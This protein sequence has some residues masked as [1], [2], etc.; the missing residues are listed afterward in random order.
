MTYPT[1]IDTF[2]PVVASVTLA[3]AEQIN[4][5]YMAI[6]A[7]E[8]ELGADVAGTATNLVTRLA[9]SLNGAGNLAFADATTLT[10]SAGA[11]TITQN[12]HRLDTELAAASDDLTT[13]NGGGTQALFLILR[14]SVGSHNIVIKHNIGNIQCVGGADITLDN[15]YDYAILIYDPTQL[16]WLALSAGTLTAAAT[17]TGANIWTNTN[18]WIAAVGYKYTA[19]TAATTL[20]ATH[21]LAD[22]DASGAARTITLPTAVGIIG[23][24]YVIRKLDSSANAVTV[25]GNGS[26]TINGTLTYVLATQYNTVRIMSNGANWMVI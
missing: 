11:A 13:I 25:D 6:T 17:L 8:T 21:Y 19:L 14:C 15:P 1:T 12:F 2:T 10:I 22:I 5:V 4:P 7:V 16:K 9:R 18:S 3:K 26:E 24:V 23:R 20:D